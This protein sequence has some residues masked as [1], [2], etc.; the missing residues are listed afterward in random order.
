MLLAVRPYRPDDRGACLA[1]FD[2]NTPRFFAPSERADFAGFLDA[3]PSGYFVAEAGGTVVG[4]GGVFIRGGA[5][6]LYW[7]GLCWGMVE[8]ARHRAGVGSL[9]L[10]ERLV[11]LARTYPK[12]EA[13]LLDTS[14]HSQTFFVRFGFEA[15]KVTPDAYA[16]GL[17]RYDMRL[18]RAALLRLVHG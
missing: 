14:Q 8:R 6:G 5:D 18:P 13:V 17:D 4:C 7:G 9:L 15:V 3:D 1:I 2:S 10:R 11:Y 16:P 12:L